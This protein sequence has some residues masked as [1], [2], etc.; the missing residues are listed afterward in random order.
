MKEDN[1]I[2][3]IKT[4]FKGRFTN[5]EEDLSSIDQQIMEATLMISQKKTELEK[6]ENEIELEEG[7]DIRKSEKENITAKSRKINALWNKATIIFEMIMETQKNRNDL[8]K[9]KHQYRTEQNKLTSLIAK[10]EHEDNKTKNV[11]TDIESAASR[12]LSIIGNVGKNNNDNKLNDTND[13]FQLNH[14]LEE[15]N[16]NKIYKMD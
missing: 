7:K 8:S 14:E 2:Q 13:K 4:L 6:I 15:L 16:N 5:L 11:D 10:Y 3:S 9:L 1:N 12:F